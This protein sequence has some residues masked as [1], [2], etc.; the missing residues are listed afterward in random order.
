MQKFSSNTV[1][2]LQYYV[3]GLKYPNTERNYF[4]IGK[5]KGNRV[6]SH[7]NQKIKNGIKDPKYD[8][9]KSLEKSGG[10]EIDI[11]RH[12]LNEKE[13]FLLEATL[14]D[15]FGVEQITN[16]VKGIHSDKYGIM[17]IK[18]VESNYKGKDFDLNISAVCFKINKAWHKDISEE[19]LYNKIRGSWSLNLI[20]AKKADYGIGVCNGVIRGIYKICNWEKGRVAKRGHRY[21]FNGYKEDKMQKYIGYSL[22]NYPG[23]AVSGPLFYYN[24]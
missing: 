7:V 24:N 13:A 14:I 4:Y 22:E 6:F 18:N 15:V 8:I 17:S 2:A 5:G 10:P 16:K 23:H 12:G 1:S 19:F 11:I 3:Y 20:R 21:L 9:I